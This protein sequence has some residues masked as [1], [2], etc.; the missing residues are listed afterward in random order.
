LLVLPSDPLF[1]SSS[2]SVQDDTRREELRKYLRPVPESLYKK[3]EKLELSKGLAS[4][5][6]KTARVDEEFDGV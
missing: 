5:N 2:V 4:A 6:Q 3:L 1:I